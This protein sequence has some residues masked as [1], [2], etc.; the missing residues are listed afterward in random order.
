MPVVVLGGWLSGGGLGQGNT[1]K[2]GSSWNRRLSKQ[3]RNREGLGAFK[4]GARVAFENGVPMLRNIRACFRTRH[5]RK[6]GVLF[7]RLGCTWAKMLAL[8][9]TVP[10]CLF[11]L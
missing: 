3:G 4:N 6:H 8:R 1:I 7:R 10:K 9:D 5:V 2:I 11:L